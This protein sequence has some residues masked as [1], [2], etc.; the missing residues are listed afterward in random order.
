MMYYRDYQDFDML[1]REYRADRVNDE[2]TRT[3]QH[4]G[5]V[6]EN[7]SSYIDACR[8]QLDLIEN[9]TFKVYV[10]LHRHTFNLTNRIYYEVGLTRYP[11]IEDGH[12]YGW[13]VQGTGKVFTGREKKAA[14]E[15]AEALSKEYSCEVKA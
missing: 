14:R 5:E 3:K 2:I 15:Y 9:T 8:E 12:R 4:M 10:Y 1:K 7:L 6:A 13:T 11:D